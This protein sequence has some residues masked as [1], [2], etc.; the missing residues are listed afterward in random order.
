M[1]D[2]HAS[3]KDV[4]EVFSSGT[5]L[6]AEFVR[7]QHGDSSKPCEDDANGELPLVTRRPGLLSALFYRRG[8]VHPC[9]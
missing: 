5:Q 7:D 4:R 3:T 2:I 6:V 8:T 9:F 1:P